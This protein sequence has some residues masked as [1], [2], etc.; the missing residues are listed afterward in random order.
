MFDDHLSKEKQKTKLVTGMTKDA[1]ICTDIGM[2]KPHPQVYFR[3]RARHGQQS[4]P[5][6]A[7]C[8]HA[9]M[10]GRQRRSAG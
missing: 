8:G 7:I 2:T 1:K 4:A 3:A 6:P 9:H 10:W 5:M